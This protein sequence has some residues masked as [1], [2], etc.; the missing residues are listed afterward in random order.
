MGGF[1]LAGDAFQA[2]RFGDPLGFA[3]GPS[4][5]SGIDVINSAYQA[6]FNQDL[7]PTGN[8]MARLPV[9]QA[10]HALF[11]ATMVTPELLGNYLDTEDRDV[12]GPRITSPRSSRSPAFGTQADLLLE[13]LRNKRRGP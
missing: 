2:V 5:D 3:L 10:A 1:A 7:S 12:V 11:S 4:V 6:I 8:M 13:T 9:F